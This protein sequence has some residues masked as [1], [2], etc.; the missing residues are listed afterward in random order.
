MA[1][2]SVKPERLLGT[3]SPFHSFALKV[4]R[5]GTNEAQII[6]EVCSLILVNPGF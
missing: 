1:R 3:D 2:V 4:G 6:D 5:Y